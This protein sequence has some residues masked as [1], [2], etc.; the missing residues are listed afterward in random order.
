MMLEDSTHACGTTW[1]SMRDA[2]VASGPDISL[3]HGCSAGPTAALSRHV[4][5]ARPLTAGWVALVVQAHGSR[6]TVNGQTVSW[7]G[8][9]MA[10]PGLTPRMRTSA[11]ACMRPVPT[12]G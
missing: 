2:G 7:P 1:E 3:A 9:P 8:H 5:R 10:P 4:L 12:P 11:K 6:V